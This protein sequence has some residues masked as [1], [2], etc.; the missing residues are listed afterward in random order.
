MTNQLNNQ[1]NPDISIIVAAYNQEKYIGRC[2]RSLLNQDFPIGSYEVVVV[3]DGSTDKTSYALELFTD[4]FD[5]V[6]QVKRND[7]NMG[8]PAALN[9]GINAS[10]GRYVVRVDSDDYVNK[11]FILVL[12]LFLETNSQVDAVACDYLLVDAQENTIERCYSKE[13]PIGCGIMFKKQHLESIGLYD[14]SFRWHED[15]DLR[16]RFDKLYKIQNIEVPLYRY[17]SHDANITKNLSQMEKYNQSLV[18]K[19]SLKVQ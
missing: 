4:P 8:L 7:C 5:S 18:E 12:Y 2:L 14:E 3:D 16:L 1:I 19:H 9:I 10:R 15:K 11:N 17:R 6:I 13:K